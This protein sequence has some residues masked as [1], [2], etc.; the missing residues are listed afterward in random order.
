[1]NTQGSAT[2][3]RS[4]GR[5]EVTNAFLRS[6]YNWMALGLG[7]TAVISFALTYT[8]LNT[9]LFTQQGIYVGIGCIILELALVFFLSFRINKLSGGAA[10]SLFMLYSALNGVSLSFVLIMYQ[11]GSVAQAFIACTGMFAAMS[12]YGLFT[13]RDLAGWGSFLFMGLI[14]VIIAM[15]VNMFMQ[16][17]M[18]TFA[19]SLVGVGIFLGLTA[20]D[21]QLLKE[22]GESTPTDNP[23]AVRRATIMGAL[24]LYLDFINLF[25]MLLRLLGDRR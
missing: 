15:I 2:L 4:A 24:R 19:I 22:M 9:F 3:P 21:T 16:S 25:M 13:K 23:V 7:L 10:T 8:S 1:M 14:G 11:V 12:L 5:V 18:M 17:S 6:V 20:Y